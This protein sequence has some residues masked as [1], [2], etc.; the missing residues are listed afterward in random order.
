M[1]HKIYGKPRN[2]VNINDNISKYVIGLSQQRL[3]QRK[4]AFKKLKVKTN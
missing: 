3:N 2:F 4:F 1:K